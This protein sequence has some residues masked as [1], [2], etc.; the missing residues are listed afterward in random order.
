MPSFH[1]N[2][3]NSGESEFY[4]FKTDIGEEQKRTVFIPDEKCNNLQVGRRKVN[5]EV[6]ISDD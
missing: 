1:R 2:D 6:N 3:S 5:S 4:Y